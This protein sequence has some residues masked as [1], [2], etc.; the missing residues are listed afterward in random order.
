MIDSHCHL[1]QKDYNEDREQVIEK[2]KKQLKA[3]ITS[4]ARPKDFNITMKIVEKHKNFIFATL[5]IHP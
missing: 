3:V 5:G 2:C 1:E 4:C